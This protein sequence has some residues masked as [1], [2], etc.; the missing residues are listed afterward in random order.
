MSAK[1]SIYWYQ[2]SALVKNAFLCNC[3]D[4]DLQER[5]GSRI[6]KGQIV[7]GAVGFVAA[8]QIVPG[9]SGNLASFRANRRCEWQGF[10]LPCM[11]HPNAPPNAVPREAFRHFNY[12]VAEVPKSGAVNIAT[13]LGLPVLQD[14]EGR[15]LIN[16]EIS[17]FQRQG[18]A[19]P[20]RAKL[21]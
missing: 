9:F 2:V 1:Y 13:N 3:R 15:N 12:A 4:D 19:N 7:V 5:S 16:V 11:V 8:E 21:I 20:R 6:E 10:T 18:N 17:S 14:S